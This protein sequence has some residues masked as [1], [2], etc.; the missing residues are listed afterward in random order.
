[1]A[2]AVFGDL[3]LLTNITSSD[4]SDANIT[5]LIAEATAEL[6]R[7]INVREVREPIDY[8]DYTRK[9]SIDSSNTTFYVKNWK[10]KYLADMDNDGDVDTSDI[11]VYQV[12]SNGTETTLTV[13]SVDHDDGKFVL[14]SAPTTGVRL[15]VTYEWC[16]KDVST[17]D[18]L[19]KMACIFLTASYIYGKLN[20]GR[21]PDQSWGNKSIKRDMNSPNYY[22][23][24][25]MKLV[26]QINNSSYF[27][28]NSE[29]TI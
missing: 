27:I 23:E 1:M 25:A 4:C 9:N 28:K 19:V 16:Q 26:D 18:R 12:D 22:R 6:N 13:S 10:G 15:Y 7:L 11:I 5:S 29:S 3:N 21:S 14:S 24:L 8:I 17:P 20:I 2:Y